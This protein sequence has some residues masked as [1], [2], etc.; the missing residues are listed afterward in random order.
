M[1]G[2][3]RMKF[4]KF[5]LEGKAVWGIEEGSYLAEIQGDMFSEFRKTGRIVEKDKAVIKAPTVN[6]II[7][8]VGANYME[9]IKESRSIHVA[10]KDPV[11]F[12]KLPT[13]VIG[14]QDVIRLPK[15][16]GRVDYE[17]EIAVMVK[18]DLA[19]ADE[20]EAKEAIFGVTCLNDV[21]AR[22]IQEQDGQWIR[23][24][25]FKTFCP[26]GPCIETDADVNNLS[27]ELR[28]N[29]VVKQ[30]SNSKMMIFG[31][32]Q[33][34]SFISKHIPLRKGDL[35]TTGTPEGIGPLSPGDTV[36]I[37]IE[38]VGI[39]RNTVE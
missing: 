22:V 16:V 25:N 24:K 12:V 32:P 37:E 11:L 2:S 9:H 20:Q 7:I 30:K 8:A 39:L 21:S 15:N 38:G 13:A 6:E 4:Y 18:K 3:N 31:I 33:L 27:F 28:Q 23:A 34:I 10:P 29:G 35:I 19:D 36:E 17:A 26:V 5:E 14:H 1:K